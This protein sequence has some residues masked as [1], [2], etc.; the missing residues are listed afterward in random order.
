MNST[1]NSYALIITDAMY[2]RVSVMPFFKNF[3]RKAGDWRDHIQQQDLPY[4]GIYL[5]SETGAP[6]GD[7]D[8]GDIRFKNSVRVG[9]SVIVLNNNSTQAQLVLDQAFWTIINGLLNDNTLTNMWQTNLPDN[10]RI[11]AFPNYNRKHVWGNAGHNNATPIAE[12]QFELSATYRS[13]FYPRYF[14]D[15][16][17]IHVETVPLADD[18]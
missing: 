6:D 18:G 2:K 14:P 15:L 3:N 5:V 1:S 12:M 10:T 11:E 4:V 8:T 7:A 17:T 13:E 9:F 16:N